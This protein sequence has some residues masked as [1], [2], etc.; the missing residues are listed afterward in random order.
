MPGRYAKRELSSG[1]IGSLDG[2]AY[3]PPLRA[4]PPAPAEAH[5]V[6]PEPAPPANQVEDA[7][8]I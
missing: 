7:N 3:Q 2:Y 5:A 1:P 4:A 8:A 6:E